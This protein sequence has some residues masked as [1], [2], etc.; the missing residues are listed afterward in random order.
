[1]CG[2]AVADDG[3]AVRRASERYVELIAKKDASGLDHIL[4][5]RYKVIG[6]PP[7]AKNGGKAS[8]IDYWI[9]SRK[10]FVTVEDKIE[11]LRIFGDTTIETGALFA[12]QKALDGSLETWGGLNYT[13]IWVKDCEVW[14]LVHE[15]Y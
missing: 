15:H 6:L 12:T 10:V 3:A 7:L 14:R 1:L 9:N 5:S 4:D 2:E 13:R 11:S 8:T